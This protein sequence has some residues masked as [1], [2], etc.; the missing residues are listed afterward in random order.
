MTCSPILVT[1]SDLKELGL[2]C[3]NHIEC[4]WKVR[5]WN[6]KFYGKDEPQEDFNLP[7]DIKSSSWMGGNFCGNFQGQQSW[8][9]DLDNQT[10]F[11][12][13]FIFRPFSHLISEMA[14]PPAT[15][16][17]F[18]C[19]HLEPIWWIYY[20]SVFS[21]WSVI[22]SSFFPDDQQYRQ[23]CQ[24]FYC[25]ALSDATPLHLALGLALKAAN[26][27]CISGS[28]FSLLTFLTVS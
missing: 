4:T 26:S 25:Q 24:P 23:Y 22:L 1:S 6:H 8:C 28:S 14:R 12:R 2:D 10:L 7:V 16:S 20:Q 21:W 9:F 17:L 11:C 5:I 19:H 3:Y 15:S 13:I 18:L 27:S